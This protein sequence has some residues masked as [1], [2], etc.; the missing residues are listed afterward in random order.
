MMAVVVAVA[1][2]VTAAATSGRDRQPGGH[3]GDG[4]DLGDDGDGGDNGGRHPPGVVRTSTAA[5]TAVMTAATAGDAMTWAQ[6]L[7]NG[8]ADGHR[9]GDRRKQRIYATAAQGGAMERR[10]GTMGV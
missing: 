8:G 3:V 2:A 9:S 5:A 1:A 7:F 6:I 10:D 4:D